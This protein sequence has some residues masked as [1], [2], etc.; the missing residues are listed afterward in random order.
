MYRWI[1]ATP[2]VFLALLVPS[3]CGD[4]APSA[5]TTDTSGDTLDSSDTNT[6]DTDAA[7]ADTSETADTDSPDTAE[8][9]RK[10]TILHTAEERGR[11]QP[12]ETTSGGTPVVRGGAAN[13]MAWWL[14]REA[15]LRSTHIV[16]SGGDSW[17]GGPT[18]TWLKGEPVVDVF[19]LMGY[20]VATIGPR[21]F[22]FGRDALLARIDEAKFEVTSANTVVRSTGELAPFVKPYVI[23]VRNGVKVAI[24]GLMDPRHDINPAEVADLDFLTL[25]PV[26]ETE[27]A[28]AR[29]D[30]ADIVVVLGAG[31]AFD[32]GAALTI[33]EADVDVVFASRGTSGVTSVN[34]VPLVGSG[35]Q[36]AG[37]TKV[38]FAF[39]TVERAAS[40]VELEY[41]DVEYDV[42]AGNPVTPDAAVAEAVAR[43]DDVAA[44]ELSEVIGHSVT[45]LERRSWAI[46]NWVTDSWLA[47]HPEARLA[48]Q[49]SGGLQAS[50]AAGPITVGA[51]VT[52][53]P[54]EN[55]LYRVTMTGAEIEA[56]LTA[57]TVPCGPGGACYAAVGGMTYTLDAQGMATVTLLGEGTFS[58]T[59]SYE[60]VVND[61][62]L[63][64]GA[65]FPVLANRTPVPLGQH[66]RDPVIA[67]TRA[68][69]TSENDPL[70]AHLDTNPRLV[71]PAR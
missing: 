66:M 47:Q 3:S 45:G 58:R 53:M 36:L 44:R 59:A 50:I 24:I 38:E 60:V 56:A 31:S 52:L 17:T 28:A 49:N 11:L 35:E 37:Y 9:L 20:D 1:K 46:S 7:D 2:L 69:A 54:F 22:D 63:G 64:G 39:D 33:L 40:I 34:G 15:Y 10:I 4:D 6:T 25:A 5:D 16:L 71:T 62:L 57:M 19:G 51:L 41:V 18:S 55:K 70:E 42:A 67:W 65:S 32:L 61:Y 48:I 13:M 27:V 12:V 21:D 68:L 26:L 30:G 43:W 8:R 23:E 14:G 29:A